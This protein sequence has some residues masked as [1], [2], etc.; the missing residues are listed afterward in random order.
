[1]FATFTVGDIMGD[2]KLGV[3]TLIIIII[4]VGGTYV[5]II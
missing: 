2:K 3:N 4:K 5:Q 1:M